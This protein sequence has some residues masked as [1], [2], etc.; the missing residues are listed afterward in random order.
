LIGTIEKIIT[1]SNVTDRYATIKPAV[2]FSTV[3]TVLVINNN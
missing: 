1:T 2:D 3:D